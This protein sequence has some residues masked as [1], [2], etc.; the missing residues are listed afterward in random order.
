MSM[1]ENY[2]CYVILLTDAEAKCPKNY[3]YKFVKENES[4]AIS[5]PIEIGD[6]IYD[7]GCSYI[8]SN[9]VAYS[10]F[11]DFIDIDTS[12][13]YYLCKPSTLVYDEIT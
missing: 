3:G 10:T 11:R 6:R 12:K 5:L 8:V 2:D 4:R 13:R 9:G 7:K 1:A